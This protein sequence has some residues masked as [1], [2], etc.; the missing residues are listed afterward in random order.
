MTV[1][2]KSITIR[3]FRN[4]KSVELKLENK[5]II[6]GRNDFGKTNFLY[7][8]RFLFDPSVRNKGFEESDYYEKN[9]SEAIEITLELDISDE[10]SNSENDFIRAY[11][12]GATEFSKGSFYIQLQGQYDQAKQA[13]NPVLKWGGARNELKEVH[14]KGMYSELD[15]IFEV[16]YLDPNVSPTALF[17]KHK[18]LLYKEIK[19]NDSGER[20]EDKIKEAIR[21]LNEVI[22]EDSRVQKL[23]DSL[24]D[25]YNDI[26]KEEIAIE[27]RSEHEVNGVFNHLIPYIKDTS[28]ESNENIHLYP[29]SGDGRQKILAYAL[30]NLIEELKIEERKAQKISIFLIE[31][32]ENSLHPS[33]QQVVSRHLFQSNKE[34]YPYVFITTHSEHVFAYMDEVNLIRI[35]RNQNLSITNE[36]VFFQVPKKFKSTRKIL[37]E[38]LAYAFFYDKVLLVE[39]MSEKILFEGVLEKLAQ[40]LAQDE[41]VK[42]SDLENILILSVEGIGFDHYVKYL[43]ELGVRVM[44]KTDNDIKKVD[45]KEEVSLLGINRCRR[46]YNLLSKSKDDAKSEKKCSKGFD[47][48]EDCYRNELKE[49]VYQQFG[50]EVRKWEVRDIYLSEIELEEDLVDALSKNTIELT[51]GKSENLVTFLQKAKKKNMNTFVN[52]HLSVEDAQSIYEHEHFKCLKALVG[53][54]EGEDE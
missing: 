25:K 17:K 29:T 49:L 34:L 20:K 16:T 37:N 12:K 7:A 15:N 3:N 18:G 31:E 46:I 52:E 9:T 41:I 13:G 2:F 50:E 35:Y 5:N 32:I 40:E 27:M 6:F 38:S 44:I 10:E 47:L 8:L 11:A 33:M 21:N 43:S 26:R 19:T 4:Y 45:G 30:T 22:S 48:A 39:G 51:G 42:W 28:R 36:S 24:T 1:K 23:N 54:G 14:Q 53:K